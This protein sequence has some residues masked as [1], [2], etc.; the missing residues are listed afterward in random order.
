MKNK[1]NLTGLVLTGAAALFVGLVG[2]V[3]AI[4][5]S[6]HDQSIYEAMRSIDLSKRDQSVASLT[7]SLLVKSIWT[8]KTGA[9]HDAS[10]LGKSFKAQKTVAS[11]NL[12]TTHG[13]PNKNGMS[14][15]PSP[16]TV[17]SPFPI[18]FLPQSPVYLPNNGTTDPIPYAYYQDPATINLNLSR[19][20]TSIQNHSSVSVPDGGA[21]AT[22]LGGVFCGL[23]FLR[24][25]L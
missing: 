3:Q 20:G 2:N 12:V 13:R 11:R 4:P 14:V 19:S 24:K 15:T 8:Q 16:L 6:M 9:I 21:T 22:M 18:S 10:L 23:V 25:K 7:A 5:I 1:F 17:Q